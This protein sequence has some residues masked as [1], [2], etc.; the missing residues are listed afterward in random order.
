MATNSAVRAT[1]EEGDRHGNTAGGAVRGETP[2][3]FDELFF[4]RTETRGRIKAGN[5]VFQRV[6]EYSWEKMIDQPHNIIRHP[7][8]PRALFFILWER[9]RAGL[10]AGAYI[11]NRTESNGYYWVY[12]IVTP[13]EGGYLSVRLKPSSKLFAAT[14]SLYSSIRQDENSRKIKPADSAHELLN[15]IRSNGF[16]DYAAFMTAALS[17]ELQART[18]VLGGT[19]WP[20]L[21]ALEKLVDDADRLLTA[22]D[23]ML[24]MVS[25]FSYT[26]INLRIQASR[27]GHEGRAIAEI[28]TNYSHISSDIVKNL[29]ELEAA[30]KEMFSGVN[31]GLFLICTARLQEEMAEFFGQELRAGDATFAGEAP[32]LHQQA[33]DYKTY[34]NKKLK[35]IKRRIEHF[36]ELTGEMKRLMSGL[37]AI[38][39]M[40][41]I[42]SVKISGGGFSDL[43]DDLEKGQQILTTGL[44][45]ISRLNAGM[46]EYVLQLDAGI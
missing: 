41:K 12:A 25:T 15:G 29:H 20:M 9:M 35:L 2:F 13:V 28:S 31:E 4:S 17:R 43:I 1:G 19:R 16:R 10:P 5:A 8:M 24:D 6:S 23:R 22:T 30:S 11:K 40:G 18:A 21:A 27:M 36:F 44:E 37:V 38:R 7:D 14:A 39:V 33:E 26:P 46:R 45:D 34:A 42:E 32:L 3:G